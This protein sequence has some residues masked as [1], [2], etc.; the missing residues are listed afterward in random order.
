MENQMVKL[1]KDT[2]ELRKSAQ[3]VYDFYQGL[4][5]SKKDLIPMT[6]LRS[7]A[8]LTIEHAEPEVNFRDIRYTPKDLLE[9]VKQIGCLRKLPREE[10]LSD[11]VAKHWKN[12][13]HELEERK[14]HLGEFSS[15]RNEMFIPWI[16][17]EESSG[18]QGNPSYYFLITK[19]LNE[20]EKIESV[21][22]EIP[23]NGLHYVTESL[24]DIPI[25][26]RWINGFVFKGWQKYAFLLPAMLVALFGLF[27]LYALLV[28]GI[29]DQIST[30]SWL[31]QWLVA[32][33]LVVWVY[34]SPLYRVVSNRIV[35]APEWMVP[36]KADSVQ[37]E[38]KRIDSNTETG[39]AIRA[40]RL[41]VYS[42]K[43]PLCA[44][45]VEVVGG[46]LEFPFRLI[47][48]CMESPMEHVYSF[49]H[50]T[51]TGKSLRV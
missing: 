17:K 36:L 40:L 48:R 24:S 37:L 8:S 3:I 33:G 45:R 50:I 5:D 44:G 47:G 15:Q 38:L 1:D 23:E 19:P 42:A 35:M 25:W 34:S 22:Y 10:D 2:E 51:K 4:T 28:L 13:E 6:L 46:G 18:G 27:I 32:I 11:W 16:D 30:V 7:V 14:V 20:I 29:H 9:K 12:L 49:D 41:M 31:S 39:H 26:A 43:C 21:T